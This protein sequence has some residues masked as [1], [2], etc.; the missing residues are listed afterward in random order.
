M[1]AAVCPAFAGAPTPRFMAHLNCFLPRWQRHR[2]ALNRGLDTRPGI[3]DEVAAFPR[4]WDAERARALDARGGIRCVAQ[5]ALDPLLA[6]EQGGEQCWIG[7]DG[8]TSDRQKR[9][10]FCMVDGLRPA[11]MDKGVEAR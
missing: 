4:R 11:L 6:T 7:E 1:V 2:A 9:P 5:D 8:T 10:E 3:I